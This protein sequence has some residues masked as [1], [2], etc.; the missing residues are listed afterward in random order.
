MAMRTPRSRIEQQQGQAEILWKRG[1][2]GLNC[3]SRSTPATAG[4]RLRQPRCPY[5]SQT[6][7]PAHRLP[8]VLL[9]EWPMPPAYWGKVHSMTPYNAFRAQSGD[10]HLRPSPAISPAF[11][12]AEANFSPM[13]SPAR[14]DQETTPGRPVATGWLHKAPAQPS[15]SATDRGTAYKRALDSQRTNGSQSSSGV[16]TATSPQGQHSAP[17]TGIPRGQRSGGWF[18]FVRAEQNHGRPQQPATR[19][20]SSAPFT[21]HPATGV[22]CALSPQGSLGSHPAA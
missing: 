6:T 14:S 8:R 19:V 4:H 20:L 16:Y 22:P 3:V 21:G 13:A 17:R 2:H 10:E 5:F 7:T 1:A 12:R 11:A 18:L 9:L 15:G